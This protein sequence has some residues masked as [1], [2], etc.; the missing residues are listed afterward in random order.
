MIQY[1]LGELSEAE[2]TE[3]ETG[4]FSDPERF[5]Q[6]LAVENDLIE[7]YISGKLSPADR[8]RFERYYL[9]APARRDQVEFFRTLAQAVEL[10]TD[11]TPVPPAVPEPATAAT[12]A[13]S[14]W[15]A[16]LAAFQG[17]KLAF[18]LTFAATILM[19][20]AGGLWQVKQTARMRDQ[21]AQI[22][23]ERVALE[24]R[25]AELKRRI[26]SQ[27]Q[28]ND[29]LVQELQNVQQKLSEPTPAPKPLPAMASFAWTMG[30]LSRETLPGDSALRALQIPPGT[31]LV[32]LTFNLSSARY[33]HYQV[34]MQTLTGEELWSFGDLTASRSG[35]GAIL[36]LRVPA[37]LMQK[38]SYS[39]V[40]SG[41][42]PTT[43]LVPIVEFHVEV[44]RPAQ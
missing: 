43:E 10:E 26:A 30:R 3:I 12:P 6:L 20:A 34:A 16:I 23:S 11:R 7:S 8:T 37:E 36:K 28:Q 35:S 44:T 31:E 32:Q 5:N 15:Q 19:L 22:Q 1:L 18:G 13:N 24:Q 33:S 42:T 39:L 29:Q 9:T 21:L 2:Q 41:D 38:G 17:P 27:Q 25:E 40:I 4:Y 14:W